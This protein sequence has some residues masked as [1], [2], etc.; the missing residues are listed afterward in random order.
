M[1]DER[2]PAAAAPPGP[3]AVLWPALQLWVA[4]ALL[5]GAL[6]LARAVP[7]WGLADST[8]FAVAVGALVQL[9]SLAIVAWFA[10][11]DRATIHW[12]APVGGARVVGC[13]VAIAIGCQVLRWWEGG[14][15]VGAPPPEVAVMAPYA[16]GYLLAFV[17]G[18]LL[19]AIGEEVAFRGIVLTRLAALLGWSRAIVVQ[20][21]LFAALHFD[22]AHLLSIAASAVLAG[23]LRVVAR[24]LWPC[25]LMHLVW[26]GWL[27]FEQ[28]GWL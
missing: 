13:V 2:E 21:L 24:A 8:P 12:F 16:L 20:A 10:W 28:F 19:P 25:V 3:G 14:R 9:A 7:A 4:L 17:L 22:G 11:R 6:E 23:W 5:F 15:G 27:V 1:A 18:A 26:N